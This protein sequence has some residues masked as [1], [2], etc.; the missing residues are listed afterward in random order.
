[1]DTFTCISIYYRVIESVIFSRL[2][3][4]RGVDNSCCNPYFGECRGNAVASNDENTVSV[5]RKFK[6][7]MVHAAIALFIFIDSF[8][9]IN[10]GS[11]GLI[12]IVVF[13]AGTEFSTIA[14]FTFVNIS[15]SA[16]WDTIN[17]LRVLA[18]LVPSSSS[19]PPPEIVWQHRVSTINSKLQL[20]PLSHSSSSSSLLPFPINSDWVHWFVPSITATIGTV[21]QRVHWFVTASSLSITLFL[22]IGR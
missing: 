1:M 20:L 13:V 5:F 14:L 18:V 9:A 8:V 19:F 10:R 3:S 7:Q 17:G 2:A 4:D 22:Q 11:S 21:N 12:F 15:I 16:D 6:H